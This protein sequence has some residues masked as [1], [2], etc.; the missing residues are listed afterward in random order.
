M[1]LRAD[2]EQSGVPIRR[3]EPIDQG[4]RF[5]SGTGVWEAELDPWRET[6]KGRADVAVLADLDDILSSVFGDHDHRTRRFPRH[7]VTNVINALLPDFANRL[8]RSSGGDSR[9]GE[10]CQGGDHADRGRFANHG[11][12]AFHW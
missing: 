4:T 12:H 9:R 10:E 2:P 3:L 7:V 8:T 1:R 6:L 11:L 5:F